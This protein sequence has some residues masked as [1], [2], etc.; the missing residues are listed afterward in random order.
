M[1]KAS[2]SASSK[3]PAKPSN[4]SKAAAAPAAAPVMPLS[5]PEPAPGAQPSMR[6]LEKALDFAAAD[7]IRKELADAGIVLEDGP[8]GTTWKRS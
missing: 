7:R 1:A 6:I 4:G 8:Q 3:T 5:A 2:K